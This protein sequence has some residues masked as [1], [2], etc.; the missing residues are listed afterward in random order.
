[1]WVWIKTNTYGANLRYTLDCS[2]PSESHGKLITA[3]SGWA[4]VKFGLQGTTLKA[5]AFMPDQSLQNSP[6]RSENYLCH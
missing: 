2:V 3:S 1:M 6:M 4:R 5:I